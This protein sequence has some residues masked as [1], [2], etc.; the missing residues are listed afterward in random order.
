M[1]SNTSEYRRLTFLGGAG[2][3]TGSKYLVETQ[4]SR[5]LVD[6]GLFQGLGELRRRNWRP[7][8]VEPRDIDAVVLT[9]AHLDHC[10]YLP[11]L[12]RQGFR[13]RIHATEDTARLAEI[14][15]RDSAHLM[16]ED[17]RHANE[18]GWSKH[19][20]ALPLYTTDD[21]L[22]AIDLLRPV[23]LGERF[24]AA[25]GISGRLHHAGHIL[26]SSWVHLNLEGRTSHTLVVSGDLGRPGHPLLNPA[27]PY[28]G[29]DTVLIESTYGNRAHDDAHA[30]ERLAQTVRE[31]AARGGS[32]LIPAFA[33]DRTEV[34]LYELTRLIRAGEIPRLPVYADSPMAL[35]ALEVYRKALAEGSRQ[36]RPE[37]LAA[38]RDPFDPGTL[39]EARTPEQSRLLNNPAVPCIVVSASGMATGGRVLHHLEQML[40]DSRHT[41]LIVGFAAAGTR[42]RALLEGARTLK[43]HGRYVPVHAQIVNLPAFSAHADAGEL[44]DWLRAGERPQTV[45]IVH[46]EPDA[47]ESLRERIDREL[48][49]T[50]VVPRSGERVRL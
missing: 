4:R 7:F 34:I 3:V 47:A 22:R 38:E 8:P 43:M 10:G 5:V 28:G 6:C 21:A 37:L 36:L 19:S 20:P 26:G 49:W 39:G 24:E 17:A 16:E 23:R 1:T 13:G 9:H 11:A 12:V 48:G 29:S 42:A 31:T 50:V 45:Y 30:V 41:V 25:A 32:V 46:G 2:T 27:E 15:L 35:A 33:V 18:H 40:P 44:V 14:V